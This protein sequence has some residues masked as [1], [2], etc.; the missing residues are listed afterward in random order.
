MNLAVFSSLSE[1]N[2]ICTSCQVINILELSKFIWAYDI[3]AF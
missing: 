2:V 3:L 1:S